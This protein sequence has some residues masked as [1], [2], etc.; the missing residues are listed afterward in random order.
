MVRY[1]AVSPLSI[2]NRYDHELDTATY[3]H[4]IFRLPFFTPNIQIREPESTRR[5]RPFYHVAIYIYITAWVGAL[6]D[7][8]QYKPQN[9]RLIQWGCGVD[10]QIGKDTA[11]REHQTR[12]ADSSFF[13]PLRKFISNGNVHPRKTNVI[14]LVFICKTWLPFVSYKA[15]PSLKES[16]CRNLRQGCHAIAERSC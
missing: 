15:V 4:P 8:T 5:H 13:L 10:D 12:T 3:Y 2:V 7:S 14:H 11:H 9:E 16:R 1:R 6:R